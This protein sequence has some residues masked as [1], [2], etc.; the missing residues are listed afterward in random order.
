[1]ARKYRGSHKIYWVVEN[2]NEFINPSES[3]GKW[4]TIDEFLA[5]GK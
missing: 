3:L 5:E 2:N 1:V 4:K